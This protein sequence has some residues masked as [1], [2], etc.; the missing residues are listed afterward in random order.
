MG[1]ALGEVLD[2]YVKISIDI[3]AYKVINNI[4]V[5]VEY[6]TTDI[7]APVEIPV[8]VG[9]I[10]TG[11]LDTHYSANFKVKGIR[12]ETASN[13]SNVTI[14]IRGAKE[15]SNG[16]VWTEWKAIKLDSNF[17]VKEDVIFRDYRYFQ[18]RVTLN[19]KDTY[20]KLTSI[21]L[22]VIQ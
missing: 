20:I 15:N 9:S 10:V 1:S 14:Q 2:K 8:E 6:K 3:P 16:N 12:I 5:Y 13:I 22:E 19:G 21:D 4:S 17:I 7:A 18:A 11:V